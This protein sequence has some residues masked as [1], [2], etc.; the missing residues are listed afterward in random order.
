MPRSSSGPLRVPTAGPGP[1]CL[2]R[3]S[4]R[5]SKP[6]GRASMRPAAINAPAR[7]TS[8]PWDDGYSP[9]KTVEVVRQ[10]R[11]E[12]DK[13]LCLFQHAGH[14]LQHG[15]S[16]STMNQKERLA[17]TL[18]RDR[19]VESGASNKGNSRWTMGL[20]ARPTTPRAVIYAK[21]HP[22]QRQGSPRSAVLDA[23]TTD[24]F[25]KDYLDGLSRKVL[26]KDADQGSWPRLVTYESDRIRPVDFADHPAQG[27]RRQRLLQPSRRPKFAGPGDPARRAD[28]SWK[29]AQYMTANVSGL[30]CPSGDEAG[31][32][33]STNGQG[34]ITA[35]YLKDPTDKALGRRR[36]RLKT[37][38]GALDGQ[39]YAGR[40]TRGR[41]QLHLCLLGVR[42]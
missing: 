17:A 24:I 35:A 32:A 33:S 1:S 39:V 29:P 42:S 12:Q 22:G 27:H 31:P 11:V 26:G 34:I 14:A 38:A 6:I 41:R 13:V 30:G 18:R 2:R 28:I 9:A 40:P 20:P 8:S 19:R 10:A 7:S 3:G 37:W 4:A 15:R 16:R 21:A 36:L 23:E 25:G 5:A